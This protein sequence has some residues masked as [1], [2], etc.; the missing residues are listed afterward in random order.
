MKDY[1][2]NR[3]QFLK[4]LTSLPISLPMVSTVGY[5]AKLVEA[6]VRRPTL[7]PEDSLKKLVLLFGPWS[8]AGGETSADFARRFMKSIHVVGSYLP[9]SNKLVQSLAGRFPAGTVAIKEIDLRKLQPKEQE[10]LMNLTKQLYNF[11]EVRL[12]ASS[13]PQWGECQTDDRMRYTR[14]PERRRL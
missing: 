1:E 4:A 2:L 7:S 6:T 8:A 3:R 5:A 9:E 14:A 10:L 11:V 13:E 12:L